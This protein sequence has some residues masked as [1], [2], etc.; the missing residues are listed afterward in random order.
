MAMNAC[1]QWR[2]ELIDCALGQPPGAALEAHLAACA[3]CSEA[4]KAWRQKA[5]QMDAGV[6]QLT[7][8]EPRARGPERILTQI[9]QLSPGKPLFGRIAL[10]AVILTATLIVV[11]YRPAP[12]KKV[13][14][15]TVMAL[16]T[17]RSPTESLLHSSADP[18]LKSV[19]QFGEKFFETKPAGDKNAQ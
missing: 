9:Q 17:W 5:A 13:A 10:A 16:S 7:T 19:P 15:F 12:P 3:D 1:P 8:A 6:Q 18:L 11:L 2:E 14:P 4:L